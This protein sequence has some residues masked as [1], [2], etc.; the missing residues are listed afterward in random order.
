MLR[1]VP[2]IACDIDGVLIRGQGKSIPCA[3]NSLNMIRKPLGTIFPNSFPNEKKQLP[4]VCLS[5][6]GGCLEKNKADYLNKTL[7]LKVPLNFEEF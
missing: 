3:I 1:K 7:Q 6:S 5:N 2:A 4:F